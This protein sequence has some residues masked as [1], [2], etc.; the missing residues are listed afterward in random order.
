MLLEALSGE[1]AV[2]RL[3]ARVRIVVTALFACAVAPVQEFPPAAGALVVA[4]AVF[5]ATRLPVRALMRRLA[6]LNGMLVL[7]VLLLAI[8]GEAPRL[9]LLGPVSLSESGLFRGGLIV[10][11]ANAVLVVITALL[12]TIEPVALGHALESLRVPPKLTRLFLFTVRYLEVMRTE[13][14][15][16]R[17]AMAVRGFQPAFTPHTLRSLGYLVGVLLVRAFDRAERIQWAMKCRGFSGR[18]PVLHA[19]RIG[20]RDW[21]F[22]SMGIA[23]CAVLA[24]W[25]WA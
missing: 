21:A 14:L 2:H 16:L 1:S 7:L 22:G 5:G 15:R 13:Y 6:P 11:K 19:E 3:D 17:R 10:L 4:L 9:S 20:P 25:G 12:G 18:Y 24:V 8:G 23:C